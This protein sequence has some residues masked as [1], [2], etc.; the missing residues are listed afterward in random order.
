MHTE[1]RDVV[2]RPPLAAS[3]DTIVISFFLQR[4][5]APAISTALRPGGRLFYQ[6]FTREGALAESP[7]N[8]AFKLENNELLSMF[9]DLRL[10]YYREDGAVD[11]GSGCKGI[12]LLVGELAAD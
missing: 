4:D 5:L 2:K 3:F 1:V 8:P 9:P 11:G 6:T 10:R 7:G 12:A